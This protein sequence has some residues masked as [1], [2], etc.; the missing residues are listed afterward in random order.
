MI[1]NYR[2]PQY[3]QGP[4]RDSQLHSMS[5][6]PPGLHLVLISHSINCNYNY[7]KIFVKIVKKYIYK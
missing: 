4:T 1:N 7:V 2:H 3:F 6:E 5:S